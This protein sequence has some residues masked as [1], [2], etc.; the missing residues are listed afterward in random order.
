MDNILLKKNIDQYAVNYVYADII[1]QYYLTKSKNLNELPNYKELELKEGKYFGQIKN[2]DI[3]EGKGK[4]IYNDGSLFEG[5]WI[6]NK[7]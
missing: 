7:K 2:K 3:L 6:D 5:E 1:S 4:L